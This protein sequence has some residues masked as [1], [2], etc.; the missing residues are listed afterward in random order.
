MAANDNNDAGEWVVTFI[1]TRYLA[2]LDRYMLEETKFESRSVA[3]RHA[4]QDW[5]VQWAM[6]RPMRW[7]R[8]YT[9]PRLKNESPFYDLPQLDQ[10]TNRYLLILIPKRNRAPQH[11]NAGEHNRRQD[12]APGQDKRP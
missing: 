12:T 8:I 6:S 5:C 9:E 11:Q 1:P 7:I 10:P 4:F 2:A 3:L